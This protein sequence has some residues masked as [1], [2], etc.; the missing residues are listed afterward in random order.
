MNNEEAKKLAR[1]KIR[2]SVEIEIIGKVCSSCGNGLIAFDTVD[3]GGSPTVW[4]GCKHCQLFDHGVSR[5]NFELARALV[6]EIK[7]LPYTYGDMGLE[8]SDPKEKEYWLNRQ[9][10]G[11]YKMVGFIKSAILTARKKGIEDSANIAAEQATRLE[12]GEENIG[13]N[14]SLMIAVNIRKLAGKV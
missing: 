12:D 4:S 7:Y 1:D 3:N 10:A 2:P 5:E 9:T 6:V 14:I 13:R 11:A 8:P